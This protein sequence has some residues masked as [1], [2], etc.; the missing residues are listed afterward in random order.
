MPDSLAGPL[1][2]WPQVIDSRSASLYPFAPKSCLDKPSMRQPL[3]AGNWK[4][5]GTRAS[6]VELAEAVAAACASLPIDTLV[7]PA[8]IHLPEVCNA[9][10]AQQKADAGNAGLQV[11]AQDCC[12]QAEGAYTGEVSALM[13]AEYGVSSV[14]VGHSERRQYYGDDNARVAA[15]YEQ[16]QTAGLTPIFCVGETA[17]ERES[18]STR[19]VIGEQLQAVLQRCG[20]ASLAN[21]VIAY[22]PVWAIGTGLTATPAEAQ[23]LHQWLRGEIAAKSASVAEN[24]R[25]LYGGSV[26]PANA[27]ELFA[28]A[29]IDGGLIGGA[30]LS[31]EDFVAICSAAVVG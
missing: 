18:G 29:D 17:A 5:N 15:K 3:V 10:V 19:K 4:L 16:V 24:L 13:L 2:D 27:A 22:E 23:D 28:A 26:K 8:Y 30:A 31:A 12:D 6:A 20:V 25:I 21:A 1:P 14:I 11:G 7:C 9:V